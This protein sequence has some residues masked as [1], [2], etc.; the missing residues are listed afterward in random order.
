MTTAPL[1]TAADLGGLPSTGGNRAVANFDASAIMESGT[2][3]LGGSM[4]ATAEKLQES[5]DKLES[6]DAYSKYLIFK[7]GQ[8]KAY[9]AAVDGL[10]PE[11]TDGFTKRVGDGYVGAG[12]TFLDSLPPQ[13]KQKYGD[14]LFQDAQ[15]YGDAA[16]KVEHGE[17]VRQSGA[18]IDKAVEQGIMPRAKII[19]Q[20]ATPE[21]DK[22]AQLAELEKE[23]DALID[24]AL[25]LTPIEKAKAKAALRTQIHTGFAQALP[26]DRMMDVDPGRPS[27]TVTDRLAAVDPNGHGGP[28]VDSV[29]VDMVR[30]YH[31]E[32]S[33]GKSR[34]D[35]LA[36]RGDPKL[37]TELLDR[38]T[39][40][41]TQLL[42][43]YGMDPTPGN[44]YLAHA[45][46]PQAAAA[47]LAVGPNTPAYKVDPVGANQHPDLF[48][49]RGAD[50]RPDPNSPRSAGEL[51]SLAKG[52]MA[53]T[54]HVNWSTRLD[55]LTYNDKVAIAHDGGVGYI[56]AKTARDKAE[57]EDYLAWFNTAKNL[58]ENG[59][60]TLL[61]L[62]Q[63][64]A[65]GRLTDHEDIQALSK[66]ITDRA[67]GALNFDAAQRKIF[68][69]A[70]FLTT[71]KGDQKTVNLFWD[72][73]PGKAGDLINPPPPVDDNGKPT[74]RGI[75]SADWLMEVVRRTGIVPDKAVAAIHDGIYS[76]D[77]KEASDA[78][79]KMD[80]LEHGD[81]RAA[82]QFFA[83]EDRKRLDLYQTFAPLLPPEQLWA[84]LDPRDQ[85]EAKARAELF[86]EGL[87]RA[88]RGGNGDDQ[89]ITL[90]DFIGGVAEWKHPGG[91]P[92]TLDRASDPTDPSVTNALTH[93]FETLFAEAYG[94]T[95]GNVDQAKAL[96]A[97]WIQHKWGVT[98]V[99]SGG[100][101][102]M[103]H[104]PNRYYDSLDNSWSWM[105]RQVENLLVKV[106]PQAVANWSV[107]ATKQTAGEITAGE[108]PGYHVVYRDP[109]GIWRTLVDSDGSAI[110]MRFDWNAAYQEN[111]ALLRERNRIASL[112]AP[113]PAGA[114]V[115]SA[116]RLLGVPPGIG[117]AANAAAKW[118]LFG[119]PD[120]G[121]TL[122]SVGGL[123]PDSPAA[124][125]FKPQGPPPSAPP[126]TIGVE[127]ANFVKS[128]LQPGPM[129]PAPPN[130]MPVRG[131]PTSAPRFPGAPAA[132]AP[133]QLGPTPP[134]APSALSN[135][136]G[137]VS[138]GTITNLYDRPIL[139]NPDGSI[140]TTS[141]KSFGFD[142]G[143]VLLPT[144]V[145]GKRLTDDEAI[146]RYRDT[147]ENL[148]VFDTPE[149]AD[150]YAEALHNEQERRLGKPNE[151]GLPSIVPQRGKPAVSGKP[152]ASIDGERRVL[153]SEKVPATLNVP[154]SIPA[155]KKF[156]EQKVAKIG[157]AAARVW[158]IKIS[159]GRTPPP[160]AA[161]LKKNNLSWM[162]YER[163]FRDF[164]NVG[165]Q[166]TL[167][168]DMVRE[169]QQREYNKGNAARGF[170][171]FLDIIFAIDASM[172][173]P[174]K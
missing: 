85:Q 56:A 59:D 37:S 159:H 38:Y 113:S 29:W 33:A 135:P 151:S 67:D 51:A 110:A 27:Q 47:M 144:V 18:S 9:V 42:K 57:R 4:M 146:K 149:H 2:N 95:R 124:K 58:A 75:T 164:F 116:G 44:L 172:G 40:E 71:D 45:L 36:L 69:G 14:Q 131:T 117:Q 15:A 90:G 111:V 72:K 102:I 99:G 80:A 136:P 119:A 133:I 82:A 60:F 128:F 98:D 103:E 166:T 108:T 13:L 74:G 153:A 64:K 158:D 21:P 39:K 16:L 65:S 109:E 152:Q 77:P 150:A 106:H 5:K 145:N 30:Q 10:K 79:L 140:S 129:P 123:P 41:N 157:G 161:V 91:I 83:P 87:D 78:F 155:S 34:D 54:E 127:G 73:G 22:E 50:G 53:G 174:K 118:L 120:T 89:Y 24:G 61:H 142:N 148:G 121:T 31:P 19:A 134:A 167:T 48:Y 3:A 17:L 169:A 46:G 141:S 122:S 92:G 12:K 26:F 165:P 55:G 96:A 170:N 101:V 76:Y 62:E 112:T 88:H 162:K 138:P 7:A 84:M 137:L 104:P 68:S 154:I 168:P 130:T 107:V 70:K 115:N 35:I 23:S 139:K 93:D 20:S 63:A 8:D 100:P 52:Q 28:F 43:Q 126:W 49:N 173:T 156:G 163:K 6:A 94:Y 125:A 143:E 132:P 97:K 105:D 66:I 171:A 81:P 25:N 114:I 160:A 11:T 86:Q 147:G 32:L 1:P